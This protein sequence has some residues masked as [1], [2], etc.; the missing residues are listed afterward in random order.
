MQCVISITHKP[1]SGI[2][3]LELLLVMGLVNLSLATTYMIQ[4]STGQ[5]A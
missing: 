4:Q 2:A 3:L 5:A 1:Q